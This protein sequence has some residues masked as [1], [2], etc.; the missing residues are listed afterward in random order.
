ME[1]QTAVKPCLAVTMGDPAGVGPEIVCKALT[2]P[3]VYRWCRPVVFGDVGWIRQ[4]A[5]SL[6]L[7]A[8]IVEEIGIARKYSDAAWDGKTIF[9]RQATDADLSHVKPGRV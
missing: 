1:A 6:H 9:V 2:S 4:T 8:R 7:P 3:D 5:Q